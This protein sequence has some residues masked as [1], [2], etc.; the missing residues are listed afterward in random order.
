M[1]R[2]LTSVS[3]LAGVAAQMACQRAPED[4]PLPDSTVGRQRLA[5]LYSGN[6]WGDLLE[7]G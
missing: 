1:R 3:L 6:L 4:R 2:W 7:C 5:I